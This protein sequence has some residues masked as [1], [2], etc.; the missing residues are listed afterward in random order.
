M[1]INLENLEYE[2]PFWLMCS[3]CPPGVIVI[4]SPNLLIWL[5]GSVVVV[6]FGKH[7]NLFFYIVY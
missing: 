4:P 6:I 5:D 7:C 2:V 3:I 1:D